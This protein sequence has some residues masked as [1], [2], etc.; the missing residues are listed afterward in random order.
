MC[1][2]V[3]RTLP[4]SD[5][6]PIYRRLKRVFGSKHAWGSVLSKMSREARPISAAPRL[7]GVAALRLNRMRLSPRDSEA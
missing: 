1:P 4:K 7:H 5:T 2:L 3:K 6:T